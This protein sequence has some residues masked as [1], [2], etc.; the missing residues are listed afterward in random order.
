MTTVNV[1]V[2][3]T[4]W[5]ADTMYFPS[6]DKHPAVAI[7]AVCGR[8]P[9]TA[10]AF[11]KTWN[12]PAS[13][14]DAVAMLEGQ[15]L[16]AVVIATANDSHYEL[17]MAAIERGLH[18]LCEKPMALNAEQAALMRDAA[19]EA[20]VITMMP[21]TYHWMPSNQWVRQ[22]ITNGYIGRPLHI[23]ARY[24]TDFGFDDSYS[25]RFDREIAGSG[26][27]GDLGSHWIHLA[28]WLLDDTETSVSALASNFVERGP[29]PDGTAYDQTEDSVAMTVRYASGAYAMLQTSAVCWEGTPFGQTHHYEVHGDKGT[30]Y[31]TC[32]WDTV[33]KVEGLR[34]GDTTG[35]Q[36][37][38]IPDEIWGDVRRDT[39]HN[40]YRDVFRT[41]SSMTRQWID[42]IVAETQVE[43]SFDE[44][45]AVQRVIDA[46]V[47][48]AAH[49]G[50]VV[51]L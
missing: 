20:D 36:E 13:Y 3:G 24:Y 45:L 6:L 17:A 27:I 41:T 21:F 19:A 28:R 40:T 30:L 34:R 37:L 51:A 38:P 5:W 35:R 16:D 11:A 18:V 44:G 7:A 31:A 9:T 49:G 12:V 43:P 26:I 42:A 25:W 8:N 22:L 47:E 15:D 29:R 50:S 4:S 1:G 33:Q 32:D 14:T 48:S 10:A 2:F 46:A 39:A 23:N